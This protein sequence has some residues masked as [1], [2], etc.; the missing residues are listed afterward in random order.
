MA[1]RKPPF[2]SIFPTPTP[3]RD[4]RAEAAQVQQVEAAPGEVSLDAVVRAQA[5]APHVTEAITRL[6]NALW[7]VAMELQ[8][9]DPGNKA[10]DTARITLNEVLEIFLPS[11]EDSESSQETE[12]F[13]G[14]LPRIFKLER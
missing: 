12:G 5:L 13:A 2:G 11:R 3:P 7:A 6:Q 10:V 14:S 1:T 4:D 8:R 9:V